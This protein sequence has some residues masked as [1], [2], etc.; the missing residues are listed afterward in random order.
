MPLVCAVIGFVAGGCPGAGLGLLAGFGLEAWMAIVDE[1][2]K[3]RQ[4]P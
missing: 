3:E 4:N 2:R 1:T